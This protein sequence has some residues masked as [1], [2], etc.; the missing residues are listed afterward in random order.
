M[1]RIKDGRWHLPSFTLPPC[2]GC[3]QRDETK[4][5]TMR[6]RYAHDCKINQQ[7][8][9]GIGLYCRS[10]HDMI[11]QLHTKCLLMFL[12]TEVLL[13]SNPVLICCSAKLI[14]TDNK[15]CLVKIQ[16]AD[17]W[18]RTGN[19]ECDITSKGEKPDLWML[20]MPVVLVSAD[21]A[22]WRWRERIN[23][24]SRN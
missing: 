3:S 18:R 11:R 21:S 8:A 20:I 2:H 4:R 6:C 13:E 9:V 1:K 16:R 14:K 22:F 23:T 24:W 17:D 15:C 12:L 5:R 7:H 19:K 10:L